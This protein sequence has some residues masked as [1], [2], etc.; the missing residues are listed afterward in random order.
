MTQFTESLDQRLVRKVWDKALAHGGAFSEIFIEDTERLSF[1]VKD[2]KVCELSRGRLQGVGVRVVEADNYGYAWLDG[3]DEK[4]LLKAAQTAA[5]IASSPRSHG[6]PVRATGLPDL[7]PVT[8]PLGQL[9]LTA[10]T[11]MAE[12][13]DAALRGLD[14]RVRQVQVFYAESLRSIRVLTSDGIDVRDDQPLVRLVA[15]VAAAKKGKRARGFRAYGGRVGADFFTESPPV[16]FFLPSA[17]MALTNLE[18]R[19]VKGGPMPVVLG[20][21][22]GGVLLHEAVGHGLEGDFNFKKSSL[23]SGRIGEKVASELVTVIDD[24]TIPHHRGTLNVD[25][26]GTL[27]ARSVLIEDGVLRGY[28]VDR[29]S[30]RQLGLKLTGNGRRQSYRYPPIP[31]MTN[32]FMKGGHSEPEEIIRSTTHGLFAKV[33]GGGQV[34]ISN[35][36]F[37]FEV[38]EGYRIENGKLTHPVESAILIGNGPEALGRVDM[39]G[40]DFSLDTGVGTCGK[41]GQ[42]VPVGVGEPTLRISEMTVGGRG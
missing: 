36:N 28:M 32:T 40:S 10:K 6:Q 7:Y 42:Q 16:P 5:E 15:Q 27:G 3:F 22:W 9:E 23:F 14:A 30:A 33:F 2:G 11:K 41:N 1:S 37:V 24:A 31:R 34:D 25:D 18:A 26:E 38:M 17:E 20:P 35:G 4:R 39:V 8:R 21:G 19:P 29:I 12:E 13:V